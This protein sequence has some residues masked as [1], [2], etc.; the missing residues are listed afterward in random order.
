MC[1]CYVLHKCHPSRNAQPVGIAEKFCFNWCIFDKNRKSIIRLYSD[2]TRHRI[3]G[4]FYIDCILVRGH[5]CL[6]KVTRDNVYVG[7]AV[8]VHTQHPFHRIRPFK[9][10]HTHISK[11]KM[12]IRLGARATKTT[13]NMWDGQNDSIIYATREYRVHTCAQVCACVYIYIDHS[14]LSFLFYI[15]RWYGT[16]SIVSRLIARERTR[17][18]RHAF[19]VSGS[20]RQRSLYILAFKNYVH[21]IV[22]STVQ[23]MC[24][25]RRR[26]VIYSW[27]VSR[28]HHFIFLKRI[29][30]LLL[31]HTISDSVHAI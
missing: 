27:N 2:R 12:E 10:A 24:R 17:C 31:N 28:I 6:A 3:S 18:C 7:T 9:R 29:Y 11:G 5:V 15:C 14:P 26:R 25:L 21:C 4:I 19:V 20:W 30:I 23:C 1:S 13:T 8:E 22:L 16:A